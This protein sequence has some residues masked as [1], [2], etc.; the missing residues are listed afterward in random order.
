MI[1]MPLRE[2]ELYRWH[3]V[4]RFTQL[5]RSTIKTSIAESRHSH[6]KR[7][8]K[9]RSKRCR[10][11][12]RAFVIFRSSFCG[13]GSTFRPLRGTFLRLVRHSS[14]IFLCLGQLAVCLVFFISRTLEAYV[15]HYHALEFPF[16]ALLYCSGK[17]IDRCSR[18]CLAICASARFHS[19]QKYPPR[20]NPL[21]PA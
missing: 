12:V 15:I 13:L 7:E 5:F 8:T 4:H 21:I 20:G 18:V 9:I 16:H 11:F 1:I 6:M 2:N 10:S 3:G 14:F 17:W 19:F